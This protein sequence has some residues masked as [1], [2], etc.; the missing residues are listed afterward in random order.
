MKEKA[1]CIFNQIITYIN[2]DFLM[3]IINLL[4]VFSIIVFGGVMGSY[5]RGYRDSIKKRS[6]TLEVNASKY[7]FR[8]G[9]AA[10]FI[11]VPFISSFLHVDY[12]SIIFPVA[13][14]GVTKF[15]EQILLLVSVSGISA[16][17]GYA[18]LD[19]LADK[20]LKQQ[21]DD[22]GKQQQDLAAEQ[23]EL[24]DELD[25]SKIVIEELEKDKL[26][27]RFELG[28]FKAISAVDKAESLM[29]QSGEELSVQKK[30]TEGLS[31]ID[32]SLSIVKIGDVKQDDYDK[33]LV[34]KAYILKRL[35]RI[36]EA[37]TITNELMNGAED[38]PIL[39]YNKACYQYILRKCLK[40]N[41]DIKDM[42]KKALLIS[43]SDPEFV[44]RQE[45]IRNKVI[46]RKEKDLEG[47]FTDEELKEL[48][49]H[50]SNEK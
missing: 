23:D 39:I 3:A 44:R 9:I 5:S 48:S 50:L 13:A 49:T 43:V 35:N 8:F 47:L 6:N 14:G 10:A 38:N 30:L 32:E 11:C 12:S 37:L 20:V 22:I 2:M 33:V 16:Y 45:K 26:I 24:K 42:V 17:L 18:L 41:S 40:D 25:Q 1:I 34:L 36:D 27:T 4:F 21:V 31:A 19:G 15:I 29:Q 7:G 28:Y 46:G